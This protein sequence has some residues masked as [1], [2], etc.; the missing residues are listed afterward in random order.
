MSD[1]IVPIIVLAI[2]AL[3][4]YF[5]IRNVLRMREYKQIFSEENSWGIAHNTETNFVSGI[6]GKGN[7]VFTS[8]K[9]SINKYL[10]N[11]SGSVI[12]FSLL[13]DAV[14]RHCDS[15][16]N[17]I[18]TLTPVPLY[19]GLAG[20]MAGVIVGLG[21][22][23]RTG[24]ITALLSSG[25]SNFGAAADG[26]NELLSGVAWAMLASICGI[27]LTTVGSILFKRYKLQGE[28]G[29]N[30]FLAWLQAKLLPELPSDTSDALNRLVKN[31]N[32]FN[33]TFAANTTELRGALTQVNESYRIQGDIIKA[34]H[35]MDVMKMAKANVR[36]LQELK[37]CTDKLEVFNQYLDD[38]HGYTDAIHTFTSQFEQESNR[39]HVLE[40]I[41]NYFTRHKAEIA[42]DSAD[43]DIALRNAL[44]TI[45]ET[46]GS[47]T[48]ELNS[49]LVQQAEEFKQILKEEK[50][51][52]E[53]VNN[54][55]KAQFGA[56]LNQIPML[57]KK[58]AEISAIPSKL[59]TLIDK[60]ERS[61]AALASNVKNTMSQTAH[62]LASGHSSGG[63]TYAP[64]PTFPTWMKWTIIV[65]VILIALACISNTAYNIW[66]TSTHTE[67]V[68]TSSDDEI[69]PDS[70]AQPT[71]NIPNVPANEAGQPGI[72]VAPQPVQQVNPENNQAKPNVQNNNGQIGG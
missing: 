12:D 43:V 56:Q 50:E 60:M 36:V 32:K 53:K 6:Y 55:I 68:V 33:N 25:S 23:L 48:K 52:F 21:S 19:C 67:T 13:K 16:E 9:D 5:F 26:V 62:S 40:E 31:L 35:D 58:L 59:D 38:I 4:I 15:V 10:G 69:V 34:V 28:S 63:V 65:S 64:S 70:I 57:E 45:K 41:R 27:F 8:I 3:Q 30:T 2:I 29:K 20:T 51:S 11:N 37:E 61:N 46:A 24:S 1:K 18:N 49:T 14:D 44:K 42:K 72:N 22:L 7:G 17:D 71:E 39:L 66:Y 47:N 54:E